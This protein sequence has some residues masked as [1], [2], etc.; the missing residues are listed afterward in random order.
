MVYINCV[1][2][3]ICPVLSVPAPVHV[4]AVTVGILK[5][6]II[7]RLVTG[8]GPACTGDMVTAPVEQVGLNKSI[9]LVEADPVS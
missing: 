6:K 8:A 9:S 3:D 4:K 7:T 1:A 5:D 2:G